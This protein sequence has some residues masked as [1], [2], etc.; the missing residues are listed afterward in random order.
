MRQL[1]FADP[2]QAHARGLS[3]GRRDKHYFPK[4]NY[5]D[6]TAW[7]EWLSGWREG[8]AELRRAAEEQRRAA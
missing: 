8:Q 1:I 3:D 2:A 6:G 4:L 5:L 7:I